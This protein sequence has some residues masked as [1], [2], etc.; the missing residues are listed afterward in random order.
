M[1][2]FSSLRGLGD[3]RGSLQSGLSFLSDARQEFL[4]LSNG[5]A[6]VETLRTRLGAVHD[7]VTSVMTT[8]LVIRLPT[9]RAC[10]SGPSLRPR[11]RRFRPT[12][13]H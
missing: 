8:L 13:R 6:G 9:F 2:V 1:V 11:I 7:G 10:L 5:A 3:G 12:Y 4:D